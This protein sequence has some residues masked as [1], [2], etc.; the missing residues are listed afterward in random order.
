MKKALVENIRE[1][2]NNTLVRFVAKPYEDMKRKVEEKAYQ[3]SGWPEKIKKFKGINE[4]KRCFIIGNGPSLRI[5]DLN[6]LKGEYTFASNAI[7]TLFDKTDWR[8]S[9]YTCFDKYVIKTMGKQLNHIDAGVCFYNSIAEKYM[10]DSAIEY[11]LLY[12][13]VP[14][15]VRKYKSVHPYISEEISNRVVDSHTVT[16]INI[17][18]ALYMGF[19]EIYLLGVDNNYSR[20]ITGEGKEIREQQKN[21]Y[22]EGIKNVGVTGIQFVDTMEEGF[23]VAKEYCDKHGIQIKN[24][25]RGGKLEVFDR[26]DIDNLEFMN[27]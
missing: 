19:T 25:T 15:V 10:S 14:F 27:E 5:N 2:S 3:K 24:A 20:K 9:Y 7:Y 18:I 12:E 6:R 22:G 16:F 17:Q 1:I 13:S 8:P 21:D 23:I 11:Y 26:V 4:G